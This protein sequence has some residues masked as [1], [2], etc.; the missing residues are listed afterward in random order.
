MTRDSTCYMCDSPETSRE[1]APPLCFFPETRDV[2]RDLRRNLVTVPSCD[3]HNSKKSKDDEFFR[4]VVLM[5]A[6]PNSDMGQHLF[7]RK[8]LPAAARM[9]HSHRLFFRDKGPIA[10]ESGRVLQIDRKRFDTC[11]DHLAKALFYDTYKRKW[12]LPTTVVSPNFFSGIASD[13]VVPHQ[14]TL[15]AV[16]ISQKALGSE[17]TRGEN[18]DVLKYR[19]RYDPEEEIYAFAAIFYDCFEVYSFSSRELADRAV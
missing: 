2:G 17:P 16:E 5:A 4:S 19:L 13:Q 7:S 18:P 3:I 11:V 15:D 9:P 12:S 14:P 1:H 6:A 10:E 8:M